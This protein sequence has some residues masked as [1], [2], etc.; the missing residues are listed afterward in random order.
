MPGAK[1]ALSTAQ[2]PTLAQPSVGVTPATTEPILM[3]EAVPVQS[4]PV[5]RKI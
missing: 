3:P 2:H 5:L 1:P 4:H